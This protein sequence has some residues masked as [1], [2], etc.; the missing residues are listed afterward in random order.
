MNNKVNIWSCVWCQIKYPPHN[1]IIW[2][3]LISISLRT[4]LVCPKMCSNLGWCCQ[5]I[6]LLHPCNLQDFWDQFSL[7]KLKSTIIQCIDIN[8]LE[9]RNW[10]SLWVLPIVTGSIVFERIHYVINIRLWMFP[11]QTIIHLYHANHSLRHEQAWI[12]PDHHKTAI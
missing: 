12:Y 4:I 2:F 8:A 5:T 11:E 6:T 9:L 3:G 1:R 7:I 10:L